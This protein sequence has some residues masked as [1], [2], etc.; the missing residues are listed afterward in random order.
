[1]QRRPGTMNGIMSRAGFTLFATALGDCAVAWNGVGLIGVWLPEATPARLRSRI[2]RRFP[3]LRETAA[4]AAVAEAVD[5]ITRLL[6]G[7]RVELGD[8]RIDDSQLGDFDRRVYAGARTIPAGRVVT[9]AALAER[10]GGAVSPRAVGQSLGR[11]PF[12]IVVPCHRIVAAHGELGG[13]SAPGGAA[14]KRRLLAIEDAR[15][16]GPV[17]LFDPVGSF[18]TGTR[19]E[20]AA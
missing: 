7:Q 4:P 8:V 10:I 19:S 1:M 11:N 6:E 15:L 3:H 18:A 14:T 5:A 13:F 17:Q 9:Y 12:P 16:E 2:E 20:S